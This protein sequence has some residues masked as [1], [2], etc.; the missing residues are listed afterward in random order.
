MTMLLGSLLAEE[1]AITPLAGPL[2][3]P[4][5]VRFFVRLRAILMLVERT[6]NVRVGLEES[7]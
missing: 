3:A 4:M 1:F 5:C 7:L 6:S 2:R